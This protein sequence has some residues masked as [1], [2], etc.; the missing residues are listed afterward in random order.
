M[1]S[2]FRR[3]ALVAVA[4]FVQIA[5]LMA[6]MIMMRTRLFLDRFVAVTML[7]QIA[8]SMPRMIVMRS[9][10]FRCHGVFL[11]AHRLP[12]NAV[13]PALFLFLRVV[14]ASIRAVTFGDR[15]TCLPTLA[16]LVARGCIVDEI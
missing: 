2:G 10:F 9:W 12:C 16:P 3:R 5:G 14:E 15:E 11:S 1:R 4:V 13:Y 7:V 8:R 6:G